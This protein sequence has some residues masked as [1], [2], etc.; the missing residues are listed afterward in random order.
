LTSHGNFRFS[1]HYH[2]KSNR[3]HLFTHF[4][5]QDLT[6]QEN[7]GIINTDAFEQQD[8][9]FIDRPRFDVYLRDA[10]SFLKGHRL[11]V[12][13]EYALSKAGFLKDLSILY[14]FTYEYKM[15]QFTQNNL[16][17]R[18]DEIPFLR[19]G[20]TFV[21]SGINN[22]TRFENLSQVLGAK[23][24][25]T[26][27]GKFEFLLNQ[28]N[29]EYKYNRVLFLDGNFIPNG[30]N[31]SIT[32]L[33]GSYE[34][35]W[36]GFQIDSKYTQSISNQGISDFNVNASYEVNSKHKYEFG[37]RYHTQVAD[38][39]NRLHQSSYEH[40]N[41]FLDF[42]TQ[43]NTTLHGSL[44][45]PWLN[46][47]LEISQI[48]DFL[49]FSNDA[50]I[51]DDSRFQQILVTPKQ[52][53]NDIQHL[54]LQVSKEFN[55]KKFGFDTRLLF[56]EVYQ[57]DAILNVPRLTTRNTL[58]Y[59]NHFYKKALYLQTGITA[60]YFSKYYAN[61]FN[62]I[63]GSF[64]VQNQQEIGNY[65]VFDLFVN[66]KIKTFRVFIKAEHLNSRF[67]NTAYYAAPNQP[68]RDFIIRFGLTWT[69]FQ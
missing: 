8:P 67:N 13:Q 9:N 48:N 39:M 30:I 5:G 1:S 17:S 65:P 7:G 24:H 12:N 63:I 54:G 26:K 38:Y 34:F 42:K 2:S 44:L 57:S 36:R 45:N 59:A 11:Y 6:N 55:Y 46:V 29:N 15:F 19:M 69:F 32:L 41:W 23:Y 3:Y 27:L 50:P 51:A 62:P 18:V 35:D 68:Y 43:K 33:S 64:F 10:Q 22:E 21:S 31:E 61:D 58:Y 28:V 60:H 14:K 20:N 16:D 4:T 40:Y 37:Y 47:N 25:L 66:A 56:Q 53:S 49:Y 52:Y